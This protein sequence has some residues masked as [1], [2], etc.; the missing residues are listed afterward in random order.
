MKIVCRESVFFIVKSFL[1]LLD[2]LIEQTCYCVG[3]VETTNCY[4]R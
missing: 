2:M 4:P 1:L 3:N